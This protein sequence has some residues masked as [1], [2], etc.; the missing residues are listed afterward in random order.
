MG[1]SKP[2]N[3]KH[4]RIRFTA[5]DGRRIQCS[6]GTENKQDAQRLHD[7]IKNDLWS[8]KK[9]DQKPKRIWQ[10]AVVKW[11]KE[12]GNK[13][14]L[15]NN[16]LILKWLSPFLANRNLDEITREVI[17]NIAE[18]KEKLGVKGS[19]VNKTLDLIRNI[20]NRAEGEWGWLDK[21]PHIR[22]RP[23]SPG[24][25]RWVTKEEVQ[26]L[27]L[28]LPEHQREI[29]IFA[30]SVGLRKSNVLKM[31]WGVIDF[32]RQHAYVRSINTKSKKAIP[33]P[34]NSIAME[35]LRKR[36]ASPDRHP[37]YVFT[38]KGRPI[39]DANTHAWR[40]ALKAAGIEDFKWHDLRHTWA[41]WH[42]QSGTSLHELQIMGGWSKSDMVQRYAHLSSD[43]LQNASERI[44][45]QNW[46]PENGK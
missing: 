38:Y 42:V 15:H 17:E 31:K 13:S 5:P 25:D 36:F 41:S 43:Q 6:S 26:R 16:K 2:K 7:K 46:S 44:C 39:R 19:T 10:E 14:S 29:T 18:K 30:L 9:I 32:D 3:R 4:W 11:I 23:E 40:K 33:V 1:I 34:L 24:R 45:V 22:R 27:L 20:L 35:I 28:F 8:Q 37:E 12:Q 21:V